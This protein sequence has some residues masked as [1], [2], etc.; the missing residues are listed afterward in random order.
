LTLPRIYA[1][2]KR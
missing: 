2:L 1:I